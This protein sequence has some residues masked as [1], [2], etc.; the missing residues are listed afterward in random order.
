VGDR[1]VGYYSLAAGSI[2]REQLPTAK[3][4]QNQPS[5]VPVIVLG[6]LAVDLR[7]EGQGIGSGL[8]EDAFLRCLTAAAAIG[9]RAIVVQAIDDEA[10]GF[11]VRLQFVPLSSSGLA[12][13]LPIETAAGVALADRT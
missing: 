5:D 4:R 8:I 12:L 7:F 3:L 9:V 13:V 10:A 2:R 6:R 1:V 11:Y